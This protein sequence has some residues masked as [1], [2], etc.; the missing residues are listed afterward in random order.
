M[1]QFKQASIVDKPDLIEAFQERCVPEIL[2]S[3]I[4]ITQD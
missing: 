4:L 2:K 3:L 1:L